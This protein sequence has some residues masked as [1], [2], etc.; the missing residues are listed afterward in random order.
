MPIVSVIIPCYNAQATIVE[1]LDSVF[2]AT[3]STLEVIVVDD[4]S[5]DNTAALVAA[6]PKKIQLIRAQH[7]GAAA[8]TQIG[9]DAATG[10]FIQYLDADDVLLPNKIDLQIEALQRQN[11]DIAYMNWESFRNNH[12]ILKKYNKTLSTSPHLDLLHRFW[13]PPAAWLF[14]ASI[15]KKVAWEQRLELF[16]DVDYYVKIALLTNK[17]TKINQLGAKYRRY[18]ESLS[19]RGGL[20]KYFDFKYRSLRLLFDHFVATNNINEDFMLAYL[21]ALHECNRAFVELSS[22]LFEECTRL[23]L[24][25]KPNFYS[26]NSLK[27]SI[28]CK[29]MGYRRAEKFRFFVLKWIHFRKL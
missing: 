21:D 4:G 26:H 12:Q 1:T 10:E 3:A 11:A 6:Y 7:K 17:F 23:I 25:L 8:A 13:S 16:Y 5:T 24:Q 9:L 28:L 19:R 15:A 27:M 2:L 22:M 14:R 20:L 18:P 29:V